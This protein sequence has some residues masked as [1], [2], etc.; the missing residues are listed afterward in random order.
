MI[1]ASQCVHDYQFLPGARGSC[2]YAWCCRCGSL[3]MFYGDL[4]QTPEG[5]QESRNNDEADMYGVGN[6]ESVGTVRLRTI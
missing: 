3:F 6:R 4:I 5:P 1:D 2:D